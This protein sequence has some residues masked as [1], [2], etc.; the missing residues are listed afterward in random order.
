MRF[1]KNIK[2]QHSYKILYGVKTQYAIF[3]KVLLMSKRCKK[4]C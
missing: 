1:K 3:V 4:D 2:N